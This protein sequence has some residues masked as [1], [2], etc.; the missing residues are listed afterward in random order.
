MTLLGVLAMVAGLTG[1]GGSSA[2]AKVTATAYVTAVCGTVGPF[3]QQLTSRSKAFN[4]SD[5]KTPAEGRAVLKTF[6]SGVAADT[7]KALSR[8]KAAGTPEVTGGAHIYSQIVSAFTSLDTTMKQAAGDA[9]KLPTTTNAAFKTAA[10]SLVST[11]RGS[12]KTIG[13]SLR[14]LKSAALIKAARKSPACVKLDG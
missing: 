7:D 10:T 9:A 4:P 2:P 5:I 3:E 14:G 8:L 1:C 13:P 11:V 12:L 6:L